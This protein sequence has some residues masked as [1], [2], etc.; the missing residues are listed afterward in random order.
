MRQPLDDLSSLVHV[1]PMGLPARIVRL[2]FVEGALLIEIEDEIVLS[3]VGVG[4]SSGPRFCPSGK[5]RGGFV[6]TDPFAIDPVLDL[7]LP[8]NACPGR[9]LQNLDSGEQAICVVLGFF[10]GLVRLR[11]NQPLDPPA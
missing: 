11:A 1:V 9:V 8:S 2:A 7:R 3:A 4:S 10:V 5:G 6:G